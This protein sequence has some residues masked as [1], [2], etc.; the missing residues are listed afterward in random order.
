M[1]WLAWRVALRSLLREP[2]RALLTCFAVGLGVASFLSIRLANRAAVASFEQFTKGVGQGSD[3]VVTGEAGPLQDAVISRLLPLQDEAWTRPV[4]EGSFSR[5]PAPEPFQLLGVDLVGLGASAPEPLSG[6]GTPGADAAGFYTGL[7]DPLAVFITPALARAEGLGPGSPLVGV[8]DERAV[9]LRVAGVVPA[10]EGGEL[11]RTLLV[12]D[13]P[14]AQALLGR[15]GELDRVDV[16]LRPGAAGQGLEERLRER[17]HPGELLELPEQR[18]Q[19]GRTMSAAFRF[20]LGV[21]SLI[22]LAVGAYLLFQAFDAAV[23]RRQE[24]WATL[25]ALG[26]PPSGIEGLVLLEAGVL[27]LLGSALGLL[28]GWGLAQG[29]VRAVSR[30]VQALYGPSAA[31]QAHLARP[32]ALLALLV[33]LATCLA[34]AWIPARRAGRLPPVQLLSR[35]AQARPMAWIR[36]ALLGALTLLVGCAVAFLPSLPPGR[37]WHAYAGAFAVMAGGSALALALIP[38]VG[39]LGLRGAWSLELALR[40]LQRPTGRHA[41]AVAALVVAVGMASGMG[42]MVHSFERTV[43]AWIGTTLRADLYVAPLGAT[44]ASSRH[45]LA[46]DLPATLAADPDVAV[47]DTFQIRP[48]RFRGQSTFLG[49]ADMALHARHGALV[50]AAGGDPAQVMGDVAAGGLASPGA[51]ASETFSRRFGLRVGDVLDLPSPSGPVAVTLRGIYADYGNERG[52]LLVDRRLLEAR[53]GETRFASLAVYLRPGADAEAVA[54]RWQARRPGLQIRSNAGLRAQ[55]S[56][57]FHQTFALTYAL[58]IVGLG[59]AVAGLVQALLGLAL[60]RRGELHTLRALGATHGEIARIL[61][62]EGL[63]LAIAGLAGGILLGLILAQIL[64]RV[65]NPQVFGWTLQYAVDLPFLGLLAGTTLLGTLVAL[66]PASRWA[67]RL[68]ADRAAEEG[69]A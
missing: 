66:L 48:L 53:W 14:A 57:V 35:G 38:L 46:P 11:P 34:A 22:G 27:G 18:A 59:V 2:G 29:A 3:F 28:L 4:I 7:Q 45:R 1:I 21:L 15:P 20:N 8:V 30:T 56:K 65:L 54:A 36:V 51:I 64:V 68:P 61:L 13:L 25:R 6:Q 16:G 60:Q 39:L 41:W 32:E 44:G 31:E 26:L 43:T 52:S 12:M 5:G 50:M 33:G 55:V 67:S 69:G 9:T 58:E 42:V 19:S 63:G 40:P 62:G 17:L 10:A 49:G 37:A 23:T 24:S 47:V